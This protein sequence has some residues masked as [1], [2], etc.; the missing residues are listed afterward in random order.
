MKPAARPVVISCGEPA[1]IG[2]EIAEAT[3][4]VLDAT[5]VDFDW[6]VQQAGADE[7]VSFEEGVA[8]FGQHLLG[9]AQAAD[10]RLERVVDLVRQPGHQA[11]GGG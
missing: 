8:V 5:G 9:Q 4:R 3:R 2:P 6:D 10:D 7:G 11:P 1:G